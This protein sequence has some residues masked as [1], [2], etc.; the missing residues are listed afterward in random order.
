M[1]ETQAGKFTTSKKVNEDFCLPKFSVKTIVMWKFHVD[2]YTNGR[3]GMIL[4]RD[5]L[6]TLG[7]VLKFSVH[8]IT[9]SKGPYEG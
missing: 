4:G 8:I 1:W 3:Y 9:G 6:N 5:P 2:E 7:L